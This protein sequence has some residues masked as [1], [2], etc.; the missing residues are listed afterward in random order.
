MTRHIRFHG[1]GGTGVRLASRILSRAAFLAGLE[2]QDSP[3]YGAERR[4]APVVAFTR[5]GPDPIRER[6]YVQSPDALVVLD[7]TLLARPDAAVLDGVDA[8]CLVLVNSRV[9]GSALAA[10][11][12]VPGPVVALDVSGI[13]LAIL[14]QHVLSAPTSGFVARA[15][16]VAPWEIVACAVRGELA[17]EGLDAAALAANVEAARQA[18]EAAPAV[19]LPERP[20]RPPPASARPIV[21]PHLPAR[22]AAP[23]ITAAA[24][25]AL[26]TTE[27]WRVHR[28]V[29]DL[30]RCTRCLVCFALCPEGAVRLDAENWPA[31]DYAHCKGCLVCVTE[32]PVDAIAAVRED[33]A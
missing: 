31:V 10:R 1:R 29:I 12:A 30:A 23:A 6:G 16:T 18:F 28:P 4:G 21:V 8:A 15:I 20:D 9:E 33:A 17:A 2:A 3:V 5:F 27:G 32:C 13:A 14:G 26:R 19:G 25:S 24:T 11:H 22:L 7:D